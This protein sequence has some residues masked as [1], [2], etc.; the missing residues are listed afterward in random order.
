MERDGYSQKIFDLARDV[1]FQP[2]RRLVVGI[3]FL[4]LYAL[5]YWGRILVV[6]GVALAIEGILLLFVALNEPRCPYCHAKMS[7]MSRREPYSSCP[8]CDKP[9]HR[10]M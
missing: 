10:P 8:H 4:F 6:I 5:P 9:F 7:V 3:P 1:F 2:V